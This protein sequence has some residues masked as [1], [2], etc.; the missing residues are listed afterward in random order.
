MK[1]RAV[2]HRLFAAAL[3]SALLAL[4]ACDGL[5]EPEVGDPAP[6]PT[7]AVQPTADL[8]VDA[9]G[10]LLVI[11]TDAPL[12]PFADYNIRESSFETGIVF[13]VGELLG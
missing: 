4:A 10:D 9:A 7:I 8:P 12:P 2:L 6:T 13:P 1:S 11:A 5:T 3:A